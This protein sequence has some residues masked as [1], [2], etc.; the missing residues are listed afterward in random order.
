VQPGGAIIAGLPYGCAK[1]IPEAFERMKGDGALNDI[2]LHARVRAA[3]NHEGP[4]P[5]ISIWHGSADE[6]V[7]PGNAE[8]LLTQWRLVHGLSERPTR[9]ESVR[10]YPRRVWC[11]GKGREVIEM[12]S[13]TAMGHGTPLE[14]GGSEGCGASAPYMLEAN[15]SSTRHI[16][17]FWGLARAEQPSA[18]ADRADDGPPAS[19]WSQGIAGIQKTIADALRAAGLMK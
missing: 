4:W 14:S 3:S 12:Y 7:V 17:A 1:T 5:T 6:T 9:M 13:I 10:G 15:I 2:E 16:A 19:G 18:K 8:A 11:D